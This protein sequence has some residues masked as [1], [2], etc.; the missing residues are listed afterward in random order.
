MSPVAGL[1]PAAVLLVVPRL[2]AYLK[3]TN[4]RRHPA[5][6]PPSPPRTTPDRCGGDAR[7]SPPGVSLNLLATRPSIWRFSRNN[8]AG[9][10]W[11]WPSASGFGCPGILRALMPF[12]SAKVRRRCCNRRRCRIREHPRMSCETRSTSAVP[13]PSQPG[14]ALY[15]GSTRRANCGSQTRSWMTP[16]RRGAVARR[17][18]ASS[19]VALASTQG[20]A[21]R[22]W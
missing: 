21:M 22:M 15:R 10:S 11:G 3:Q 6:R 1:A 8:L 16:S 9:R 18:A 14:V 7:Y 2:L 17:L 4:T 5:S 13:D 20:T 19:G 12:G